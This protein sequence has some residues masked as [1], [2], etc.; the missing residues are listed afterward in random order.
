MWLWK[1]SKK[2]QSLS[3]YFE[4]I[5]EQLEKVVMASIDVI[6]NENI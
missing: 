4:Q 3:N 6:T 5:R 1:I 2:L